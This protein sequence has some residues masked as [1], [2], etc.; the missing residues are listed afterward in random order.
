MEKLENALPTSEP[1]SFQARFC[2]YNNVM[3][4]SF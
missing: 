2:L 4:F 3:L 1:V